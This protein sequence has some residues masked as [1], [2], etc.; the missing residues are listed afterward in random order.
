MNN[1]YIGGIGENLAVRFLIN[2]GFEIIDRN[3]YK[4]IGEI[5]IICFKKGVLHF[6]EVKT[7][8]R[9]TFN[10]ID[11][12]KYR[13]ENNV[14]RDKIN[15]IE[16]TAHIFLREKG[17]TDDNIQIDLLTVYILNKNKEEVL[18]SSD[19]ECIIKYFPNINF[20]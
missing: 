13:P 19:I 1:K 12:E 11:I 20:I 6:F 14:T 10:Y 2:N 4:K 7:V 15:K 18:N 16:K 5:D 17:F 3:Y 8:S 9:E